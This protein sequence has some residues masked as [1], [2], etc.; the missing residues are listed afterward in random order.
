MIR[1]PITI[2]CKPSPDDS[3]VLRE[4]RLCRNFNPTLSILFFI[5]DLITKI[6]K[7]TEITVQIEYA[8]TGTK[9]R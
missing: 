7:I 9:N 3:A 2:N 1:V 6:R 8:E 4:R 5:R